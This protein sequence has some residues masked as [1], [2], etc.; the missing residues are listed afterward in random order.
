MASKMSLLEL[1]AL[2]GG[3]G[4][5][6]AMDG[7]MAG[8]IIDEKYCK[9]H[10]IETVDLFFKACSFY[11]A[12]A[13]PIGWFGG[14]AVGA[15]VTAAVAAHRRGCPAPAAVFRSFA[16]AA[17]GAAPGAIMV[18][19]HPAHYP[20]SR[21]ALIMVTPFLSGAGAALAVTGC[22]RRPGL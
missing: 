15:T 21:S 3:S 14:S 2:A 11:T 19:R 12:A 13:T 5:L 9:R 10:H 8:L 17:L 4:L 18:A 1:A 20:P 16:G 7:G 6:G 22:M